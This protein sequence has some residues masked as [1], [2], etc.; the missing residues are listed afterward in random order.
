MPL[1]DR[2]NPPRTTIRGCRGRRD[3]A[4]SVEHSTTPNSGCNFRSARSPRDDST[5]SATTNTNGIQRGATVQR[6]GTNA[7]HLQEVFVW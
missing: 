1:R 5:P 4:S 2:P 3:T 6:V 7:R